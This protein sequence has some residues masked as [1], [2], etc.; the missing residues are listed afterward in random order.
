MLIIFV[1]PNVGYK[2]HTWEALGIG[3][4]A[5]YLRANYHESLE[6][7]FFSGFYDSDE[8]IIRAARKADVI[9]FGCTS[10]QYKHGL[11]LA[12]LIKNNG[13]H[14]AFGGI[15][16]SVLPDSVLNEDCIDNVV[17]GEGEKGV[18]KLIEDITKGVDTRK[19]RYDVD[20]VNNLDD[21]P[22]PDRKTI[23]NERNIQQAYRD[24]DIRITSM[25]AS[26]GC[27]FHCSFCCSRNVWQ[28][29]TRFRSTANLLD[30]MDVL[31]KDWNIQFLKFADDTF[32]VS[33]PR[34]MDFCKSKIER[35]IKLSYGANAHINT[36]D[37]ELLRWLADSGCRELWYGV[38]SGSPRILK[39]MNKNTNIHKI[40]EVF[41]LTKEHGIRTRAYFLLGM[42][43]ETLEDINLTEKLCDELQP[44]IVGFTLLAP[45]PTN[46][47]Y[48][49]KT[50]ADWDWSTFDEYS[51]NWVKTQTLS[52]QDLKKTQQRLVE[53]YRAV[54]AFRQRPKA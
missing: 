6:M 25:L 2:G 49:A 50:M 41:R 34:V 23:K 46:E 35:G 40:K 45:F 53:K 48:D 26:R 16:P 52:N 42:P 29:Q 13:N 18:L 7:E 32:T 27:P 31:V 15:H 10:P 14:I 54:A 5:A 33:R 30:E 3:Y 22:F 21:I 11:S 51:N 38:E 9:G 19:R 12:R 28:N 43:S 36:I 17:I 47:Y 37:A 20:Y 39:E 44:D 24:E 1:Q 4:L 8:E